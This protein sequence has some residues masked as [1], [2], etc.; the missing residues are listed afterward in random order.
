MERQDIRIAIFHSSQL[1]RETLTCSLAHVESISVVHSASS[2]EQAG[3]LLISHNPD[4]LILQFGLF[5]REGFESSR[6]IRALSFEFKTMV[7]EVP[8]NEEDILSCMEAGGASGYLLMD[9]S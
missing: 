8:H 4:L 1:F 9:A 6:G 7:I 3:E 2:L 5:H